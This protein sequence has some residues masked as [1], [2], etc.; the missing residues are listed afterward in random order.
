R[1]CWLVSRHDWRV[2]ESSTTMPPCFPAATSNGRVVNHMAIAFPNVCDAARPAPSKHRLPHRCRPRRP[3]DGL[4]SGHAVTH[5]IRGADIM[6]RVAS[7]REPREDAYVARC[8]VEFATTQPRPLGGDDN[9]ERCD[10]G[11]VVEGGAVHLRGD[12]V[13]C[14]EFGAVLPRTC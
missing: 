1:V 8:T 6:I 11:R 10:G 12:G 9:F 4:R 2:L 3:F 14:Q 5:F 7:A 13:A